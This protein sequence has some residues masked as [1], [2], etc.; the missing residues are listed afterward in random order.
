MEEDPA[1][2]V[3]LPKT[4]LLDT[5]NAINQALN[6][7]IQFLQ[8]YILKDWFWSFRNDG[9]VGKTA[10]IKIADLHNTRL[11]FNNTEGLL[12][13]FNEIK[14]IDSRTKLPANKAEDIRRK[15]K[16]V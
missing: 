13:E 7:L 4:L 8:P 12:L 16:Q 9:L 2:L 6:P 5:G 11:K 1:Q 14:V 10:Q 15:I 3:P